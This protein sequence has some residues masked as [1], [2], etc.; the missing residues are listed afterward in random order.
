MNPGCCGAFSGHPDTAEAVGE[1]LGSVLEELGAG[2]DL[3]MVMLTPHHRDAASEIAAAIS[4]V[5]DPA[6]LIGTTASGV[7]AGASA[8]EDA[9]GLTLWAARFASGRA[10]GAR[11]VHLRAMSTPEGIG[12]TG[13][14][15]AD[16]TAAGGIVILADPWSFPTDAFV[17]QVS[18]THPHLVVMGGL[19]SGSSTPGGNRLVIGGRTETDGAVAWILPPDAT[20]M[21]VVSQGCRPVGRPWTVTSAQGNLLVELAGRP[22]L[23][24]F[25][26]DLE[27]L[28]PQDRA[29]AAGGLHCGIL[30]EDKALDPRRGDFL[31][32]GVM[33]ADQE[34]STVAVGDQVPVGS[35]VQLHVRDPDSAGEDLALR[36]EDALERRRAQGALVFTCNGRGRAM[37]GRSDHDAEI[38]AERVGSATAGLMCAG[39]IGPV[40]ERTVVHGFTASVALFDTGGA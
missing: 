16:L 5:L 23:E 12:I 11:P 6:A 37:F 21:P 8:V 4:T 14:E 9:P 39:E 17:A 31:V 10:T 15:D 3:A 27:E 18:R 1:V 13:L 30:A 24:R 38:V 32:R 2:V 28:S 33:G 34:R 7:L 26:D 19:A 29:V 20:P 36:L 35:V 22:A 40:A 25:R